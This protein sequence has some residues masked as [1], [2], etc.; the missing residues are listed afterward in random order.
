[1]LWLLILGIAALAVLLKRHWR[2]I[3]FLGLAYL[4][5]LYIISFSFAID[6][7]AQAIMPYRYIAAG[8]GLGLAA[9]LFRRKRAPA[10]NDL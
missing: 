6:R 3:L 2:V 1:M 10:A 5:N 4:V 7:Y 8:I 9:E